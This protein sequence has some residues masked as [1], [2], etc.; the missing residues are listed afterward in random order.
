[1]EGTSKENCTVF[2][3]NKKIE[4]FSGIVIDTKNYRSEFPEILVIETKQEGLISK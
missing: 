1:M 3:C 2:T 4:D